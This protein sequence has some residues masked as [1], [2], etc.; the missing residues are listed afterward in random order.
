LNG[1]GTE[2]KDGFCYLEKEAAVWPPRP[3]GTGMDRGERG[4]T[5]GN[6]EKGV[7]QF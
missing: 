4:V 3:L 7:E 1:K 2:R 5:G 6:E